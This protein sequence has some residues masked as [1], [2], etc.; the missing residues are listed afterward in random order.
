[1]FSR[2]EGHLLV[3][4]HGREYIDFFCGAG[5]VNYGHNHPRL[6]DALMEYLQGAGVVH[7]LDAE[8]EARA[9]FRRALGDLLDRRSLDYRIQFVGP[10][11]ANA[12]EAALK[13]ARLATK[14]HTVVSFTRAYHGV[15][16][17]ALA[18]TGH[19]LHR[20]GA[21]TTLPAA[22]F[23]PYEG[24]I[25]GV[26]TIELLQR[27]LDDDLSGLDEPAAVIV[28]S[29]QAEGG[30][31]VATAEWL[32]NVEKL[33]RAYGALFIVDEIQ[34]G[35]G[36]TGSFFGFERAGVYPDIICLSKSLSGFGLPLS[37][38]LL[39]PH[40]DVWEAGQHNGTFR[41]N[42]LA[43][44]TATK[45]LETFWSDESLVEATQA[46]GATVDFRLRSLA[47]KNELVRDVRG[48][49]MLWGVEFASREAASAVV[50]EAF[51]E[52]LLVESCGTHGKVVKLMPPLVISDA[53]LN[54]GLD[55]LER[56]IVDVG[57]THAAC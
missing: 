31:H 38:V 21:G 43:C 30:V 52:G 7:L 28:E 46:R 6:R 57:K 48:I 17:G 18:V 12:V 26:D 54:R 8:S 24:Y 49:G 23:A 51:N 25:E 44:V 47:D 36:R 32:R 13:L 42:N 22:F 14:R 16:L 50:S 19:A 5:A 40:L 10:T 55:V 56:A 35:C 4:V 3:D 15:S 20:R 11:G 37:V 41:S 45:A 9:E 2:A 29:T 34:T 39:R 53:E 33:C 1:V 27:Y